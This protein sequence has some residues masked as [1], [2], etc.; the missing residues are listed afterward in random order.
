MAQAAQWRVPGGVIGV[1]DV[2]A[3]DGRLVADLG[4]GLEHGRVRAIV[5]VGESWQVDGVGLL[6][7]LDARVGTGTH[8]AAVRLSLTRPA[9]V[10]G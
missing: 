9:E 6:T 7:V 10:A 5:P 2:R 3:Q 4:I 8:R 1:F